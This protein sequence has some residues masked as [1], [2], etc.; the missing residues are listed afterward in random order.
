MERT[1][2]K[3]REEIEGEEKGTRKSSGG[4]FPRKKKNSGRF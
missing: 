2:G 3:E 1:K 4:R